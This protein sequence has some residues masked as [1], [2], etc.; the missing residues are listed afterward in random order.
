ML[1]LGVGHLA[2]RAYATLSGGEKQR[3]HVARALAQLD[4][5]ESPAALLL[6]EP[7]A[8]LDAAHRAGL[9]REVRVLARQGLAVLAVLHDLNEAAFVADRVVLLA[10][11]RLAGSGPPP[12][13]LRPEVLAGLYGIPFLGAPGAGLVPDFAGM[14]RTAA[15]GPIA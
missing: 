4:G 6:D 8:S 13:V 5:A 11:G 1:R 2:A 12:A 3:V 15:G 7:T 14:S 10:E 9:L